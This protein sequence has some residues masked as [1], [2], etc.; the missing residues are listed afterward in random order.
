[1]MATV[2]LLPFGLALHLA[3][4]TMMVGTFLAGYLNSRQLWRFLPHER[5]KALIVSKATSRYA[6]FQMAGGAL[7]LLGGIGMMIA[8]HG[9]FMRQGWFQVKMVLLALLIVNAAVIARPA[10][11]KL[12]RMLAG[13]EDGMDVL[14]LTTTRRRLM[15]FYGLQL[16][17]FLTIFVLSA[18]KFN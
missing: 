3:G 1:M 16:G 11:K 12:R 5:E 6:L 17:L 18:F 13:Q 9:V 14:V 15:V 8:V 4:I 2:Q 10:A 7:I